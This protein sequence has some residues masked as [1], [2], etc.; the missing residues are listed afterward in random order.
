MVRA[1][2]SGLRI[3]SLFWLAFSNR[4]CVK[5]VTDLS[6]E[7]SIHQEMYLII[8]SCCVH[9]NY[10]TISMINW[11]SPLPTSCTVLLKPRT[12]MFLVINIITAVPIN[13]FDSARCCSALVNAINMLQHTLDCQ[14]MI[15]DAYNNLLSVVHT[16]MDASLNYNRDM[17]LMAHKKKKH[18]GKPW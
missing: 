7:L 18:M 14:K 10:Q 12:L 2:R 5:T 16:E 17:G 4:L 9:W 6:Q 3:S 11:L 1:L 15:N 8:L 13:I